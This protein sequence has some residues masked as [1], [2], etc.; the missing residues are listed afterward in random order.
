MIAGIN[1]VGNNY[2]V[3]SLF[4][5]E[6]QSIYEFGGV[7]YYDI[8]TIDCY[9]AIKEAIGNEQTVLIPKNLMNPLTVQDLIIQ[10][11][12]DPLEAAR[13]AQEL[14]AKQFISNRMGS[15][16]VFDFYG[17]QIVNNRLMAAGY[18]VTNENREEKYL[19]IA[20]SKDE[21]LI[22][23]L[24]IYLEK[25]DLLNEYENMYRQFMIYKTDAS[26]CGTVEELKT[27]L[28]SFYSSFN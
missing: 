28:N 21:N 22:K 19:E 11:A 5:G 7:K 12:S 26:K 16:S 17:F 23:L 15:L 4:E 18:I 2:Q 24:E 6:E 14:A 10:D 27:R 25:M 8:P 1:D 20:N 9:N 3:V 13:I